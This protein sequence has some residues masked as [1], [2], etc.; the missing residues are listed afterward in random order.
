MLPRLLWWLQAAAL[1]TDRSLHVH[2]GYGCTEEYDIQLYY[3]RARALAYVLDDPA[4]ECRRLA[5]MLFADP[6]GASAH[7]D[8]ASPARQGVA[9]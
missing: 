3:R 6:R 2:G 1:A 7:T 4:R 8:H 9:G 5:G